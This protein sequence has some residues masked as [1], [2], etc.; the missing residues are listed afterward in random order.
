M[1]PARAGERH[2]GTNLLSVILDA[3]FVL[4]QHPQLEGPLGQPPPPRAGSVGHG[5]T[6][7]KH[8]LQPAS[9]REAAI[10]AGETLPDMSRTLAVIIVR[11]PFDW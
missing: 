10:A 7:H 11:N 3:N 2:S 5:C 1:P 9:E 8:A 6:A 4:H